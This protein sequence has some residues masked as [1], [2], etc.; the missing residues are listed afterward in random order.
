[1]REVILIHE[2]DNTIIALRNFQKGERIVEN[3]LD[4]VLLEDV[5]KGHKIAIRDIPEGEDIIKYGYPIGHA[6]Y[7]YSHRCSHPYT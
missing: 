3:N 4:I 6:T 1:M 2:H 5:I 7:I